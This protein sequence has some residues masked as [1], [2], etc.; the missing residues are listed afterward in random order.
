MTSTISHSMPND[1]TT[2]PVPQGTVVPEQGS[3][4]HIL[5]TGANV[6]LPS[7]P[8]DAC[9]V[10]NEGDEPF[11]ARY[12]TR[13]YSLPPGGR[14]ILPWEVMV[15]FLGNPYAVNAPGRMDRQLFYKHLRTKYG[16]YDDDALWE[17]N[18]PRLGAYSLSTGDR[19]KTVVDDPE[20]STLHAAV[21]TIA[22]QAAIQAQMQ[23]MEQ[24]M[25]VLQQMLMDN[26]GGSVHE[27]DVAPPMPGAG[28]A[29]AVPLVIP[30]AA[31]PQGIFD[32]PP[33]GAVP[34]VP[35][36]GAVEDTP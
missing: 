10:I 25:K 6:P 29:P 4:A 13:V 14:S 34:S 19:Y 8:E 35:A 21:S 36:T 3:V 1:H 9:E 16:A 12:L 30:P 20:G 17:A 31:N 7:M 24:R 32:A 18:K 27:S 28:Q 33:P 23:A 11:T 26:A 2:L 15:N 22:D 5:A